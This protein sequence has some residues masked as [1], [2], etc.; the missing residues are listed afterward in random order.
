VVFAVWAFG[1]KVDTASLSICI[2]ESLL[3]HEYIPGCSPIQNGILPLLQVAKSPN[4]LDNNLSIV[5]EGTDFKGD[6]GNEQ[7]QEK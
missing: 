5:V 3:L 2:L 6:L 4:L 1:N 7:E